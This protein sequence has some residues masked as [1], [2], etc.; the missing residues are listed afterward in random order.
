MR[1][2]V[3][4]CKSIDEGGGENEDS[5][6]E[7]GKECEMKIIKHIDS[8]WNPETVKLQI[9]SLHIHNCA[10]LYSF[11]VYFYLTALTIIHKHLHDKY[12]LWEIL[13]FFFILFRF[14]IIMN[15]EKNNHFSK[16]LLWKIF[17]SDAFIFCLESRCM[18]TQRK[19]QSFQ[20]ENKLI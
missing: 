8:S 19:E 5:N 12:L 13:F 10:C 14:P 18:C 2:C 15:I 17:I 9:F 20:F 16:R 1:E 7:Y 3:C 6:C 11:S 4:V